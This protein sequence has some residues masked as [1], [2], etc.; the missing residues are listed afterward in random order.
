MF[1]HNSKHIIYF[2]VENKNDKQFSLFVNILKITRKRRR[3]Q[4]ERNDLKHIYERHINFIRQ[5]NYIET[6]THLQT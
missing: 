6:Y 2:Q 4:Y 1:L 5:F 3:K